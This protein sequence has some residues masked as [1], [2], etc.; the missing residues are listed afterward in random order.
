MLSFI[1]YFLSFC[2]LSSYSLGC[3]FG[4]IRFF[5]LILM[6]FTVSVISLMNCAFGAISKNSLPYP[7]SF[8]F[9]PKL[10]SRSSVVLH[11]TFRFVIHLELIFVESVRSVSRYILCIYVCQREMSC[12]SGIISLKRLFFLI[13]LPLLF[14]QRSVDY[15]YSTF[16]QILQS[17][18]KSISNY[19]FITP[20]MLLF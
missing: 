7:R 18:F 16:F 19:I 6:K 20:S 11:F 2:S 5:F 3:V 4:K 10:S 17:L 15:V 13:A 9:S 14:C 1:K 8:R 12:C